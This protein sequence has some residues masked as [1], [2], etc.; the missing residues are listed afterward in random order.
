[1]EDLSRRPS[2]AQQRLAIA[3][4]LTC[5]V[6]FGGGAI[7]LW[8]ASGT[9]PYVAAGLATVLFLASAV[10]LIRAIWSAPRTLRAAEFRAVAWAL[11][12]FGLGGVAIAMLVSG[13]VT[14]ELLLL[15]SSITC[16]AAGLAGVRRPGR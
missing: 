9:T 6:V 8:L 16:I 15:G 12:I 13:P 4:S 2:R 3:L 14:K 5:T 10:L 1:M 7:L 11:L